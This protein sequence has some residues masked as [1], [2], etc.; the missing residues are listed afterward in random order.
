LLLGGGPSLAGDLGVGTLSD[1]VRL[2]LDE[3]RPVGDDVR[4]E[5]TIMS[6]SS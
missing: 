2:T 6:R 3:V 5:A 4:I 1:A